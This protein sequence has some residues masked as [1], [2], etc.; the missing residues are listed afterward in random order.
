MANQTQNTIAWEAPEFT[1][2][3]KNIGWYVTLISLAILLT[4]YELFERDLFGAV[5]I[6][7]MLIFV[8]AFA[9]QKPQRINI[10][11]S[12]QGV[13][14]NSVHIP[15]KKIRHFWLVQTDAHKTLNMETTSYFHNEIVVQLDGQ[16]PESI[17][18]FLLPHLA[19]HER[20]HP[21]LAQRLM[22]R[23]KF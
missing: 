22:H 8:A 9:R 6:I 4:G 21:T 14:I 1:H 19:E 18:T 12:T 13:H 23:L 7:I 10:K 2:Y 5:S 11:L 17:R 20:T 16:D 15:Y 3:H